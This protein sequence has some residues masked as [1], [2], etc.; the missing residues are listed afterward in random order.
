MGAPFSL[1]VSFPA[2]GG[3]LPCKAL[4][5][6]VRVGDCIGGGRGG[7]GTGAR[8]CPRRGGTACRGRRGATT[9]CGRRPRIR[10]RRRRW[11]PATAPPAAFS[12]PTTPRPGPAS[13]RAVRHSPLPTRVGDRIPPDD[14]R[15]RLRPH[16]WG[17]MV[18]KKRT[19]LEDS[20]RF[21]FFLAG[22]GGH[23]NPYT[24]KRLD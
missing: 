19:S 15:T 21:F 23:W 18:N 24:Q 12:P 20:G 11:A 1:K 22:V 8:R 3:V 7:E 5:V 13:P 2:R 14:R 10:G 16:H 9:R 4:W 17:T 6:G